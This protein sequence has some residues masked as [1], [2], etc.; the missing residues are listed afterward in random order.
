MDR[1]RVEVRVEASKDCSPS[2]S[3]HEEDEDVLSLSLP[4]FRRSVAVG[5][6]RC[7]PYFPASASAPCPTPSPTESISTTPSTA[8]L[9]WPP[10]ACIPDSH[11]PAKAAGVTFGIE[12]V[13][14]DVEGG[15][16][17]MRWKKR[18]L[19]SAT[20]VDRGRSFGSRAAMMA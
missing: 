14:K 17:P 15:E 2:V 6:R 16:T 7:G 19:G 13:G 1:E 11:L 12:S 4:Y 5:A 8:S 20:D 18:H 9:I 10:H 3:K